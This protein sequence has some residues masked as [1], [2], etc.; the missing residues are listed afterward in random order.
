M[1]T[2]SPE[3]MRSTGG[4]A[5]LNQ[6]HCVVSSVAGRRCIFLPSGTGTI[7]RFGSAGP[8][9]GTAWVGGVAGGGRRRRRGG[10]G[11]GGPGPAVVRPAGG[12]DNQP[13]PFLGT[14]P[15]LCRQIFG[16]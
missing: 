8:I 9:G 10:G 4:W 5:L 13:P 11:G 15:P 12:E 2:V 1:T 7:C 14:P 6:P 3:L 16:E